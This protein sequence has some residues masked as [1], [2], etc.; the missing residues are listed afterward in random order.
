MLS[1]KTIA[2]F[3]SAPMINYG[4]GDARRRAA[5]LEVVERASKEIGI[6]DPMNPPLPKPAGSRD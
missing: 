2:A 6:D 3:V 1:D 4:E 5:A